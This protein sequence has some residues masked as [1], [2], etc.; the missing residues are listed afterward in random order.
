MTRN[1]KRK[2]EQRYSPFYEY[3][4]MEEDTTNGTQDETQNF[5]EKLNYA[6]EKIA[7]NEKSILMLKYQD[8][9]SIKQLESK[10]GIKNSAVKMRVKRARERFALHY[11]TCPNTNTLRKVS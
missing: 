5:G 1:K 10:L 11:N 7:P 9:L 6:L 4:Y 3:Q 8:N 2:Y